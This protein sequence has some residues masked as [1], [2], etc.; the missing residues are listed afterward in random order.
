MRKT[1]LLLGCAAVL[2][3][4]ACKSHNER[5][6]G[7]G[8]PAGLLE[9][10]EANLSAGWTCLAAPDELEIPGRIFYV[11][12]GVPQNYYD[13]SK[14][15]TLAAGEVADTDFSY[16]GNVSAEIFAKTNKGLSD[17]VVV[18]AGGRL[19]RKFTA[20]MIIRDQERVITPNEPE[21]VKLLVPVTTMIASGSVLSNAE[22]D[23]YIV[24]EIRRARTVDLY[25]QKESLTKAGVSIDA[26]GLGKA[27]G[28]LETRPGGVYRV[29][30]TFDDA[31][32]V[33][34]K[35]QKISVRTPASVTG[36]GQVMPVLPAAAA[37]PEPPQVELTAEYWN[38]EG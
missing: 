37:P 12:N 30:Q 2:G 8:L 22:R 20:T 27:G 29:N 23:Y 10:A 21:L 18:D 11:E 25:V 6:R 7:A 38:N 1:M 24:R 35:A 9:K 33:C 4:G 17:A 26:G 34:M 28:L 32:T 36:S 15:V 13:L 14:S 5:M 3:L 19:N 31:V 16:T